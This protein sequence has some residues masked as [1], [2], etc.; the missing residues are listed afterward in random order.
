MNGAIS[1]PCCWRVTAGALASLQT[2]RLQIR[3]WA[4]GRPSPSRSFLLRRKTGRGHRTQALRR[5]L[6]AASQFSPGPLPFADRS[7]A[8]RSRHLPGGVPELAV[9]PGDPGD[10]AVGL[11]GAKNRPGLG[12]DLMDLPVPI[13]PHPERC[14]RPRRALSR[15]R[16]PAPGSWPAPGRSSDRSSGCDPRRSETGA[17]RRRPFPHARRHRSSAPSLRS[18][19][20]RRSAC[21][22][23]QTR[24]AGRQ[25]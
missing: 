18:Q 2:R 10:E 7:A 23:M 17:G 16:R 5:P 25:T 6:Q 4:G 9:D 15:R 20:R 8:N 12:I 19:D 1:S 21:L 14:L 13:L 11:D 22:R 24:R 3:A